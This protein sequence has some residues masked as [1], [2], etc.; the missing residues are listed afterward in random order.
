MTPPVIHRDIKPSNIIL[1]DSGRYVLIDF[2]ASRRFAEE[3]A[4][5]TVLLGTFGYAAP[6]QYGFSQTEARICRC[7][8]RTAVRSADIV[9]EQ[10]PRYGSG[11]KFRRE[12]DGKCLP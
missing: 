8:C 3:A 7:G 9:A 12:N 6:E 1:S 5:D 4:E 2:D 10:N 11:R